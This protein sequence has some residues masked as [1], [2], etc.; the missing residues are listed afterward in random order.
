[1]PGHMPPG[2]GKLGTKS[3]LH[4]RT[5]AYE[6]RVDQKSVYPDTP[7]K[8]DTRLLICVRCDHHFKRRSLMLE[9]GHGGLVCAGKVSCWKRQNGREG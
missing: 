9:D 3:H 2:G 8:M 6:V 1:M 5:R 4:A 7:Q